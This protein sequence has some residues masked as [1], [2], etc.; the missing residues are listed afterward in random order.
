MACEKLKGSVGSQ[1]QKRIPFAAQARSVQSCADI[2]AMLCT[3]SMHVVDHEY[4]MIVLNR[5]HR[6]ANLH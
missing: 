3:D 4:C 2:L 1:V 5:G 6:A